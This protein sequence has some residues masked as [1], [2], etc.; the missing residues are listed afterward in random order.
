MIYQT[1]VYT[2]IDEIKGGVNMTITKTNPLTK[3]T[4][5]LAEQ[6]KSINTIKS[7][8]HDIGLFFEYFKIEPGIINRDQIIEYKDY[9]LETRNN[10]AKTINR[11]LSSLKSYNEFLV[12]NGYQDEVTILF[13]DYR[14]VQKQ[15]TSP[16]NTSNK[17]II[18]FM[19]K[20]K[21]NEPIRNYYIVRLILNT[22]LRVSEIL[23]I[24]LSDID[25]KRKNLK[26]VG[27]GS[28][29]RNIPLNDKAIEIIK[30][31]I[32]D[33]KNYNYA[34]NV[35]NS[36]YLF[37]S[38][39][40]EKLRSSTIE[41]IFNNY[42]NKITPHSLRH[43]FATDYLENGGDLRSLQMILGHGNLSTTAI[44]THPTESSMRRNIN[45][46]SF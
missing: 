13:Q 26:I 15:L 19:E 44:Y 45:N 28:K 18:N 2:Y 16:T 39:K 12:E 33:R 24:E 3:Y 34:F 36:P 46:C 11:A 21:K 7:Y 43:M 31:A 1:I 32:E 4:N 6:G 30:M 37:L 5:Y 40:S 25:L 17:E 9:L 35:L 27:K 10:D 20:V 22:G 23:S 38:N 42:S 14:K 29:Q 8:N 41:R